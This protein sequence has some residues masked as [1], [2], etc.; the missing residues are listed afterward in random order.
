MIG[1]ALVAMSAAY[2]MVFAVFPAVLYVVW[3]ATPGRTKRD[4]SLVPS[5]GLVVRG[6]GRLHAADPDRPVLEPRLGGDAWDFACAIAC[7]IQ[8]V[9]APLWGYA[10]PSPRHLLG[11]VLPFEPY[12]RFSLTA[13]ERTPYLGVITVALIAYAAAVR[14][15]PETVVRVVVPGASGRALAGSVADDRPMDDPPPLVVDVGPL[16][17]L[18]RHKGAVP[19]QPLRRGDRR[20]DR[21]ARA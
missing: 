19:A 4:Q 14:E 13:G 1:Y 5:E 16:P 21:A 3:A 2:Y 7:R 18:P 10:M 8:H 6:D 12:A 20:G 11:Q 15:T 9:C 17:A